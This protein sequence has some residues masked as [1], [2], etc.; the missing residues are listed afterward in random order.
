MG[1]QLQNTISQFQTTHIGHYDVSEQKANVRLVLSE[2]GQ[3]LNSILAAQHIIGSLF[4]ESFNELAHRN[5][6]L[7]EQNGFCFRSFQLTFSLFSSA[8]ASNLTAD[9]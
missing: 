7:H 4:E 3:T 1:V 6:I 2:H 9:R 8:R 5:I